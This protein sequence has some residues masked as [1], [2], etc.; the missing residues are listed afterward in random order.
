MRTFDNTAEKFWLFAG[1]YENH[2]DAKYDLEAVHNA[3]D[4]GELKSYATVGIHKGPD[5]KDHV[6]QTSSNAKA[7]A[8]TALVIGALPAFTAALIFPPAGLALLGAG[9][10]GGA[11]L[12]GA[13][14][15]IGH[16]RS[17]ASKEALAAAAATLETDQTGMVVIAQESR[18]GVLA[19][20]LQ[21]ADKSNISELHAQDMTQAVLSAF[22]A[23]EVEKAPAQASTEEEEELLTCVPA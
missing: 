12:G 13:G 4:T 19:S 23:V 20:I 5:G 10:I 7:T 16:Y 11:A 21:G 9:V 17:G 3:F 6:H 2:E 8:G 1:T 22:P 14:G 15:A 18:E